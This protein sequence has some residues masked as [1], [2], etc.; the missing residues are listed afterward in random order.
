MKRVLIE[1]ELPL[2][3]VNR[4]S[5][6]EKSLRHGH[7]STLHLWWARRPL[8]MSRT[9]VFG[10][11]MPDPDNEPERR[12]LLT[13][14][15]GA[16]A[17]EHSKKGGEMLRKELR[18]AWPERPPRVL[19]CFAGGGAIP[20]EASRLGCEVHALDINPVA[21]L[22]QL[23]TLDYPLRYR[24]Q[25]E[26]GGYRL[27][28]DLNHWSEW[29]SSRA[30]TE[31]APHFPKPGKGRPAIY[32]WC[33]TMRC[34]DG[35]CGREIPLLKSRKL[36]DSGRRTVRVDLTVSGDTIAITVAAGKPTDG[37]DWTE[38]TTKASSVTCPACGTTAPAKEV[39]LY[40]KNIGF[41]ARLY[42]VMDV[43]GSERTYREPAEEELRSVAEAESVLADLPDTEDGTSA[44]PD[45]S[46]VKSQY[47]RYANLVY[48]IDT[49]CGLFNSR[50]L[51]VLGTLARLVREASHEMLA[52]G[53]EPGRARAVSTYLAFALDKVADYNSS[54]CTWAAS[55][56][57]IRDTFPQQ[58][59]RMA[60]DYTEVDPFAGVSGSW[61]GSVDWIRRVLQH[62]CNVDAQ[63]ATVQ[64]G[65]AQAIDYP[66]GYFDAVVVDP[67]Y[68]DAFQYGDLSDFFYVWLKR[69]IGHL[70]PE[71]FR[72]PLT[73]KNAEI[74]ENRADK[75]SAEY[76]SHNEFE[77][78]LQRALN[79]IARVVKPDG[80]VTLVFAHTDVEAWE[81]L[82]RA[83]RAAGLVVTTSW[84]M[85]SE[86]ESRPTAQV[87]AVLGSSVVLV[88]RVSTAAGE[89]FYDDVVRELEARI[90]NRLATFEEMQ[91]VGADYF[92]SA[93]GPAFE[94]FAQYTRVVR[95]SGEEVDVDEL[96]VLARQSVAHHAIRRLL[97]G[98]NVSVLD[99]RSL[100]Y[101]TWRWAYDGEPIP[102][103]EAYKLGR[104]FDIDL[105]HL[106]RPGGLIAKTGDSFKLLGPHE[107]KNVKVGA[108]PS[109]IDVM[110]IAVQLHDAGRRNELEQLL[111]ASAMGTEPG[112]WAAATAIAESLPDGNRERTMLLGLTGSRDQ[113][114]QA[115]GRHVGAALAELTLFD[116]R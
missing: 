69:S 17:F 63:P 70:Y 107:R 97:G 109:P 29:I 113:L 59:I 32:F 7:I 46:M 54:F 112:F 81:S 93:I 27:I 95:L 75:K 57:F 9:V 90:A 104:A 89:G 34:P 38:G 64:R 6:K 35:A 50:Q 80:L 40:A 16:A 74:I 1:A 105:T 39:R 30:E 2:V 51:L 48:G 100:M 60:W 91:L 5:A 53:M 24:E 42:A 31:L 22:I 114:A 62:L 82:L 116:T 103:D 18:S 98:E 41:G 11:L 65:N 26:G 13:K 56:E 43:A 96:M 83:L 49:W 21:H 55:G 37:S 78:R 115:S 23:A 88:C 8:S 66:D 76:I 110:H 101:L 44:V 33:R 79:E 3:Q 52:A 19:D 10:S 4:E 71:L 99:A 77:A 87:S 15:G 68:Y 73:P 72:T 45:E 106:A 102:A 84:P 28:D 61:E 36:A 111:G 25:G 20:L 12:D 108:V 86:R 94:V 58:S 47:R 92:I 14:V 85:R 67:P